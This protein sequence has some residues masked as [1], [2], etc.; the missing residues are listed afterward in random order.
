MSN[1]IKSLIFLAGCTVVAGQAQAAISIIG[2]GFGRACYEA[3]EYNRPE[4]PSLAT[5][6]TA[7]RDETQTLRDRASTFVNRGII[8][9]QARNI[10]A[11]I[12]DYDAALKIDPGL[13]E[14]YVNKGIAL[15]HLG[16]RDE[17]AVVQ[18]TRGLDR[19]PSRPEIAYYTRGI[20]YEMT[21]ATRAAYEDYKQAAEL[22]PKWAE[23]AAQLLRFSI[24]KKP[25]APA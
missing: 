25:T 21:G 20:A 1:Q 10:V 6:T 24:V 4:K 5:C 7:L 19:K 18:L 8:H 2:S 3:A 17:E 16:G 11:A 15:V 14:A 12:E 9:M 22:A 13:A 23:P